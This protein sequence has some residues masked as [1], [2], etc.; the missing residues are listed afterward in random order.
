[1]PSQ[2]TDAADLVPLPAGP[3]AGAAVPI[4]GAA[5]PALGAAV[6]AI[7]AAVPAT[8]A[9]VPATG[10]T[11]PIIGASTTW[12]YPMLVLVVFFAF[13]LG[14]WRWPILDPDYWYLRWLG[15]HILAGVYPHTNAW[16][17]TAP[18]A[19]WVP[20]EPGVGLLY[21]LGG[22][23]WAG[24]LRGLAVTGTGVLLAMTA[25]RPR[26]AAATVV[27]FTWV[28]CLIT[29]GDTE[30]ALT[31]GNLLLAGTVLL[32]MRPSAARLAAASMLVGLWA[33]MHG[34][35]II[36]VFLVLAY[37]WRW[38]C[39]AALLTLANPS[40]WH[41]WALIFGYGASADATPFVHGNV[42]AE[43][44]PPDLTDP[45]WLMRVMLVLGGTG[46]A[47]WRA[48]WRAWVII[49]PVLALGLRHQRCLE[50][51]AIVVLP[52]LADALAKRLPQVP[53]RLPFLG[54]GAVALALAVLTPRAVYGPEKFPA[55]FPFHSL[56]GEHVWNDYLAGGFLAYHGVP[57]FWDS[58]ADC[59]PAKVLADGADIEMSATKRMGLL[60]KWRIDAVVTAHPD[61]AA[62]LAAAGWH[63][64]GRYGEWS[65]FQRGA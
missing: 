47:L 60:A 27:G 56:A 42:L 36:G 40:G 30:R 13:A 18:K 9:A 50:V 33:N 24:L 37:D 8:G 16:G 12:L 41:L 21:A 53:M 61:I 22:A 1:M 10:A 2:Q 6:A 48:P 64:R 38:G 44:Q 28:L 23:A 58:R 49:L 31:W 20:L 45:A 54:F 15:D 7:G 57:V 11:V 35:F 34:S 3:S 63:L 4:I 62:Q 39:V 59:Y 5:M 32:L 43:W 25:W 55:N 26:A 65:V 51:A 19:A 17:W 52:W 29:Y 14:G 46:L